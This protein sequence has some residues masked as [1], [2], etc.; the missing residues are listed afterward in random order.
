[1]PVCFTGCRCLNFLRKIKLDYS[2][3]SMFCR[4]LQATFSFLVFALQTLYL[5]QGLMSVKR[6]VIQP[7]CMFG[8]LLLEESR[9][10]RCSYLMTTKRYRRPTFKKVL[11]GMNMHFITLLLVINTI[12][13][14]QLFL[15]INVPQQFIPTDQQVRPVYR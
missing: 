15:D 5:L 4:S 1:M 8:G 9:L 12:L 7:A 3:V 2:K 11:H 14:S 10:T 13:L 6:R